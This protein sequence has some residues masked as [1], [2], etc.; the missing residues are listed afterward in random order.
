MQQHGPLADPTD[1]QR[2]EVRRPLVERTAERVGIAHELRVPAARVAE[3]IGVPGRQDPGV[4]ARRVHPLERPLV[5]CVL[6]LGEPAHEQC[7][8]TAVG[9]MCRCVPHHALRDLVRLEAGVP[10]GPATLRRDDVRG[11]ARDQVERLARDRLEEAAD[12][13]LEVVDAVQRGVERGERDG[14][15]VEVCRDHV[16]AVARRE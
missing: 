1:A 4:A 7:R 10:V 6:V 13:N 9:E 12:S 5:R 16:V 11:V 14:A 3:W 15:R 2:L 8:E